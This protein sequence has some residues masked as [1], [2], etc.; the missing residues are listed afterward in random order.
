MTLCVVLQTSPAHLQAWIRLST[1]PLEPS[2]ASAA[3]KL[4]AA[5]YAGASGRRMLAD[6]SGH[7]GPVQSIRVGFAF[8]WD[9]RLSAP[10]ISNASSNPLRF[11]A[12]MQIAAGG[13]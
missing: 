8:P 11:G 6:L 10:T 5:A 9:A 1:A 7:L 13:T 4:L 3:G 12:L 2:V